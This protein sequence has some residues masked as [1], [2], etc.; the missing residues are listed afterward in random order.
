MCVNGFGALNSSVQLHAAHADPGLTAEPRGGGAGPRGAR[1]SGPVVG[2]LSTEQP[3]P[4][5]P[6]TSCRSLRRSSGPK[7]SFSVSLRLTQAL[8]NGVQGTDL[9]IT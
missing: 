5:V 6:R 4:D 2:S 3:S 9:G 1:G 8:P 7:A